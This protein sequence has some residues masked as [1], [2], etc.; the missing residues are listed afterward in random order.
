MPFSEV[1]CD[2]VRGSI[3]SAMWA[4]DYQRG[5][6]LMGRALGRVLVHEL[7]HIVGRTKTHAPNGVT[8]TSLSGAQLI[9]DELGLTHEDVEF[10]QHQ[11]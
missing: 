11:R 8:K 1:E 2:K 4:R 6:M 7:Y 3:R 9:G 10:L 5:D